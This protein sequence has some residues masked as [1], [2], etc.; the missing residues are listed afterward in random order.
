M[1]ISV[2]ECYIFPVYPIIVGAKKKNVSALP[3]AIRCLHWE[4]EMEK[5]QLD[6]DS[7]QCFTAGLSWARIFTPLRLSVFFTNQFY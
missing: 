2:H 4:D 5:D 1:V 3:L 7:L 6:P